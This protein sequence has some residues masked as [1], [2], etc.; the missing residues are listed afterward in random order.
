MKLKTIVLTLF[1]GTAISLSAAE[2]EIVEVAAEGRGANRT[3][4]LEAAYRDAIAKQVGIIVK[5][6]T[7]LDNDKVKSQILTLSNGFIV[8]PPPDD[9]IIETK[10]ENGVHI[11]VK[12]LKVYVEKM[13]KRMIGIY[14]AT[15]PL[16]DIQREP[17]KYG[18]QKFTDAYTRM[19]IDEIDD[20]S[21][22]FQ[23]IPVNKVLTSDRRGNPVLAVNFLLTINP[24]DYKNYMNSLCANLARMN[25][26][27]IRSRGKGN[28]V[29]KLFPIP[30]SPRFISLAANLVNVDREMLKEHYCNNKGRQERHLIYKMELLSTTGEV[31][32]TKSFYFRDWVP[33]FY[34][35]ASTTLNLNLPGR[36]S[37]KQELHTVFAFTIPEDAAKVSSVRLTLH[38]DF[39]NAS[40]E[41]ESLLGARGFFG[42]N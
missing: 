16:P 39:P 41:R 14:T 17:E 2:G 36:N 27:Q 9:A 10:S 42:G 32:Q 28:C 7:E 5:E 22:I 23:I 40:A 29:V 31:L 13:K 11:R 21:R 8:E 20:Y 4:A 30:T 24:M 3:E 37:L 1:L 33:V 35:H 15:L 25:F 34:G 19:L 6:R 38:Y 12:G 18:Y 26:A